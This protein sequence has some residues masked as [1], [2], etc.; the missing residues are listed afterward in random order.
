MRTRIIERK[1]LFY[2]LFFRL[3][4][5]KCYRY[6]L[7]HEWFDIYFVFS[8]SSSKWG[9]ARDFPRNEPHDE[10]RYIYYCLRILKVL[11][12]D[13]RCLEIHSL[14]KSREVSIKYSFKGFYWE[15][16]I[17]CQEEH[18]RNLEPFCWNNESAILNS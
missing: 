5:K 3:L 13:K 12:Q 18:S 9:A 6:E 16:I 15:S 10:V 14:P 17:V 2:Y 11:F 1:D 8:S 4:S 7:F